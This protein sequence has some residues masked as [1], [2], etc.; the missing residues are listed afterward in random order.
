MTKT[1]LE[2]VMLRYELLHH[3]TKTMHGGKEEPLST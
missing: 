3:E 1:K 2:K